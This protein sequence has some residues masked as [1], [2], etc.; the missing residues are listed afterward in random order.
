M[1]YKD[2]RDYV[3]SVILPKKCDAS[4]ID[5]TEVIEMFNIIKSGY[6]KSENMDQSIQFKLFSSFQKHQQTS[7]KN[8]IML[9]HA[10]NK[11]KASEL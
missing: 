3:E 1:T 6:K 4:E 2:R 9:M 11:I 7:F 5:K 10:M 8:M